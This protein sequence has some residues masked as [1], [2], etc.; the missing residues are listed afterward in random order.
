MNDGIYRSVWLA[1]IRLEIGIIRSWHFWCLQACDPFYIVFSTRLMLC[2]FDLFVYFCCH[3]RYG[4]GPAVNHLYVCHTC[5]IESER[6]EKRRKNELEMF[7]RVK[8]KQFLFILLFNIPRCSWLS[9]RDYQ[10]W[11]GDFCN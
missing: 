4:G 11:I 2:L 1:C 3:H 5:Q 6:L 8:S 7:I 10:K 9:I